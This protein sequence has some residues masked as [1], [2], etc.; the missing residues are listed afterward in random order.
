MIR[1]R[2][3]GRAMAILTEFGLRHHTSGLTADGLIAKPLPSRRSWAVCLQ[4]RRIL[5]TLA[6][7]AFLNCRAKRKPFRF[8]VL[9]ANIAG[10]IASAPR[11]ALFSMT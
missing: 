8:R 7:L 11:K 6:R 10:A 1:E 9:L 5:T 2:S 4:Q 3:N